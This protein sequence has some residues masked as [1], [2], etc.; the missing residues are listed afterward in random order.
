MSI[1]AM[2]IFIPIEE[3]K[4]Q[5]YK[6]DKDHHESA[7]VIEEVSYCLEIRHEVRSGNKELP[8]LNPK[9]LEF[10]PRPREDPQGL[11][12][13]LCPY[14]RWHTENGGSYTVIIWS[15]DLAEIVCNRRAEVADGFGKSGD[16]VRE[17]K[18]KSQADQGDRHADGVTVVILD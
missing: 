16:T 11:P 3:D 1:G 14:P 13:I 4:K 10:F 15:K 12:N 17:K 7:G 18:S 9:H 5:G 8:E 2:L 6:Q